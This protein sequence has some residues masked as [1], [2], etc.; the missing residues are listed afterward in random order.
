VRKFSG[1]KENVAAKEKDTPPERTLSRAAS[2]P[3]S[4]CTA[5]KAI[6]KTNMAKRANM[7]ITALFRLRFKS[8][9][10]IAT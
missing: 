4:S 10:E 3:V 6:P 5:L 1:G 7:E 8:G 9:R 2:M